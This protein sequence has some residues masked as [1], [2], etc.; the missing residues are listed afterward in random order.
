METALERT[1]LGMQKY[2]DKIIKNSFFDVHYLSFN[3]FIYLDD[4][5]L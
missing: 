3:L 5:T 2:F 4:L 1:Y